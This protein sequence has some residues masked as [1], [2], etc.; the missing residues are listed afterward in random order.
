MVS[1]TK[2]PSNIH[3]LLVSK[4][5]KSLLEIPEWYQIKMMLDQHWFL[6]CAILKSHAVGLLLYGPPGNGK[7]MLAKAVASKSAATFFSISASSLTS[8]WTCTLKTIP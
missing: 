2:M 7:T 5:V 6:T 8:K 4:N 3:T 1:E